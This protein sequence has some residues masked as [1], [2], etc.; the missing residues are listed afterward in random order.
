[1]KMKKKNQQVANTE[2]HTADYKNLNPPS[3]KIIDRQ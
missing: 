2:W 3:K 1:M